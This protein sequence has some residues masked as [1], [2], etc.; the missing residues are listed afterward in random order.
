MNKHSPGPWTVE[1]DEQYPWIKGPAMRL[2]W[3]RYAS[4]L[5]PAQYRQREIDARLIAAAPELLVTG[6][7]L[8]LKLCEVYRA[9]GLDPKGCQAVRDF[10]AAAE[11]AEG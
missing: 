10:M 5:S 3:P 6:K 4:G 2:S 8:M 9:A 7:R 1:D 11:K